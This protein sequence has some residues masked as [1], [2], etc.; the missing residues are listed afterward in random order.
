MSFYKEVALLW[1]QFCIINGTNYKKRFRN[2]GKRLA[3]RLSQQQINSSNVQLVSGGLLK[4]LFY[5]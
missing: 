4:L 2:I 1:A 5:T 3:K